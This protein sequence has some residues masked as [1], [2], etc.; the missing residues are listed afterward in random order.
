MTLSPLV[1]PCLSF[2]NNGQ[3]GLFGRC[4]GVFH[5]NLGDSIW[6]LI[7][8]A[9][10]TRLVSISSHHSCLPWDVIC[11]FIAVRDAADE[12]NVWWAEAKPG[13]WSLMDGLRSR[14]KPPEKVLA[15]PADAGGVF[16][17][18][19]SCFI[20]SFSYIILGFGL[21]ANDIMD[22]KKRLT[23]GRK[24]GSSFLVMSTKRKCYLYRSPSSHS[25]S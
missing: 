22:H 4:S 17:C 25:Y 23:D 24:V 6:T 2:W 21:L 5:S 20:L 9:S 3:S 16:T 10:L 15:V 8:G 12:T 1:P 7:T 14:K 19:A 13:S 18:I 11:A